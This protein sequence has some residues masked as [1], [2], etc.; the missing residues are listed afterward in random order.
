LQTI[1]FFVA[2]RLSW[3]DR[4]WVPYNGG[5][6]KIYETSI[7]T[8][9]CPSKINEC[10]KILGYPMIVRD[11]IDNHVVLALEDKLNLAVVNEKESELKLLRYLEKISG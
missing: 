5:F 4:K 7:Y 9:E 8:S 11:E 2:R 10:M 6:Y 1:P 3:G